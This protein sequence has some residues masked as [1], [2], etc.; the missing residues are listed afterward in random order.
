[1]SVP[2]LV[3]LTVF[4]NYALLL[5]SSF[6]LG[7]FL[8]GAGAPVGFQYSAEISYPSPESTAQGL[9]L[10]AGQVSGIIFIAGMNTLG[11]IPFMVGF[12]I[13]MAVNV[14]ISTKISESPMVLDQ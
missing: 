13:L 1:M 4:A 2:G 12:C 7:F 5:V 3:G 6:L 14:L 11:M 9:L 8:L 10:L